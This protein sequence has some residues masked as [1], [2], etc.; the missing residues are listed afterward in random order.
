MASPELGS[1]LFLLPFFCWRVP[2]ARGKDASTRE[3]GPPAAPGTERRG[4]EAARF[5]DERRLP[6]QRVLPR[7]P[8]R[9]GDGTKGWLQGTIVGRLVTVLGS[10]QADRA[11][12]V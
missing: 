3:S 7:A 2:S 12:C 1:L 8:R 4:V 5:R 6:P 11:P 10:G 9:Q